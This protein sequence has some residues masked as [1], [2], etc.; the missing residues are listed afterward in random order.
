VPR[1][2]TED[3]V[4]RALLRKRVEIYTWLPLLLPV[5]RYAGGVSGAEG[6]C[7]SKTASPG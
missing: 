5:G 2:A 1:V 6:G 4:L 7:A 3:R